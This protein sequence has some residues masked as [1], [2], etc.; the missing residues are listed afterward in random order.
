MTTQ[1]SSLLSSLVA[2]DILVSYGERTVLAGVDLRASSGQRVGLIGEN[3]SGKS[4]LLR[5]LAGIHQPDG[6]VVQR[7]ADLAYLPQEPVFAP[8]ASVGSVL[9]EALAPLH[10]AVRDLERLGT[11]LALG[12]EQR[13]RAEQAYA[14]V[15]AWAE[16]HDAWGADRRAAEATER[17]GVAGLDRSRSLETLSGGQRSR[18]AMAAVLTRRPACLLLDEPTNHL[19]DDAVDL[20]E[21]TCLQLP[22]VVVIASHDRV[23]LDRVCTHLVD[24]DP[25]A[26]GTDGRGG[27]RFAGGFSDYLQVKAAARRRWELAFAEQQDELA[28][29]RVAASIQ[30]RD[31][32]AGR[33]PRDNDKFITKFKGAR[34]DRTVARRVHDAERRLQVAEREALPRPPAPL[35]LRTKLAGS[36]ATVQVSDLRVDGRLRLPALSLTEGGRLLVTGTNGSGKSTLLAVLAGRLAPDRGTIR[37]TGRAGLLEQDTQLSVPLGTTAQA[38]YV[39]AVGE[40]RAE[41]VPLSSLGLLPPTALSL[42]VESLSI[43]QQRRLALA[44]LLADVPDLVLLD[45]PTNHLSLALVSELEEAL[46]TATATVVIASHDR[47][48]RRR[49][50]G[51]HLGLSAE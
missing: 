17:L 27:N 44:V 36:G 1:L 39:A 10:Q 42:P 50:D 34:V 32:A 26:L 22:G 6:G 15:L 5:V 3:G 46:G 14:E 31:V 37:V 45:E 38:A 48:L 20:V 8:G 25:A 30:D 13:A 12:G 51:E 40:E 35:R 7:P 21:Q 4:T 18:I 33:G 29:L 16:D 41:R 9:D 43:G 11:R 49:W 24:L 28:R 19:D 23:L 2:T 47:W